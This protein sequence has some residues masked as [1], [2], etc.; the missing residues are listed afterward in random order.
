MPEGDVLRR[1]ADRFELAI[2]GQVLGAL[3]PALADRRHG[4]PGGPH[5]A[6]DAV[7][8]Q[9][10]A[11]P[12]RRRPHPAHAPAHGGVLADRPHRLAGGGRP[13]TTGPSGPRHR[14]VDDGRIPPGHARR[15]AHPRRAHAHR[16]SGTGPAR[17]DGSTSTRR[18]V[19][20]PPEDRHLSPR[21]FSTRR[22]SRA[23]ARSS[24]RSRCSPSG[25]GR[26]RRRTRSP[27]LRACWGSRGGSSNAPSPTADHRGTCTAGCV[28]RATGAEPP[29]R[30][31]GPQAADAATDLLLPPLPARPTA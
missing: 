5:G 19:A 21:C 1:T 31:A 17:R 22:S 23:S 15:G 8:R 14:A 6:G 4:G 16:P 9:A 11:H 2:G 7:L 27:T 3:R 20:G 26:G 12:L 29:S 28:S 30:S 18:C 24:R 25:C 10:P 13:L